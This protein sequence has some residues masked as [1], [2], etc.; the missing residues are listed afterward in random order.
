M[1]HLPHVATSIPLSADP[2]ARAEEIVFSG[3]PTCEVAF[4]QV[5]QIND[6]HDAANGRSSTRSESSRLMHRTAGRGA[7]SN[8]RLMTPHSA[9]FTRV[10]IC[11]LRRMMMG[12]PAQAKSVMMAHAAGPLAMAFFAREPRRPGHTH[13]PTRNRLLKSVRTT[14]ISP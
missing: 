3:E 5:A 8:P 12:K 9:N 6:C 11:S 1:T 10:F 14:S 2:L 4:L 7:Y 13:L